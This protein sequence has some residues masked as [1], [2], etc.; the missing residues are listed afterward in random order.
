MDSPYSMA[1]RHAPR[2][3]LTISSPLRRG[4]TGVTCFS[5]GADTSISAE[6]YEQDALYLACGGSG[7]FCVGPGGKPRPLLPG[8]ALI[9]R[10]RELCGVR[11]DDGLVYVEV[12]TEKEL[13]VNEQVRIGKPFSL[14]E[15][16]PYEQGSIVNMDV[17]HNDQMK[18]VVMSFDAGMALAPHRASGDALVFALEGKATIGY[19]GVDHTIE[20]GQTFRFERGGLHSVTADGPF[21]M[22]LLLMLA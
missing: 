11:A 17:A 7:T 1:Q 4:A 6:S 15:L 5:M 14:A 3:G 10:A 22:A 2:A 18:F 8:G 12:L 19:E 9:V 16:V 21:K 13:T 20:A